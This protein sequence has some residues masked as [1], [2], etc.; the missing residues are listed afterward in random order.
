MRHHF[1]LFHWA[2]G[3]W[4]DVLPPP[5]SLHS[6]ILELPKGWQ[7]PVVPRTQFLSGLSHELLP[8]THIPES[9]WG[10]GSCWCCYPLTSHPS[11]FERGPLGTMAKAH[12]SLVKKL[13]SHKHQTVRT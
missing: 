10:Q 3:S 4:K 11:T 8:K 6:G 5:C 9:P 13:Q 12:C 2:L 7:V 1:R